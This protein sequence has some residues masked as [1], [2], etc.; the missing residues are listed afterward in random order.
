MELLRYHGTAVAHCPLS[1]AYFAGAVFPLRTALERGLHVGLGSDISG[2]LAGTISKTARTA[3]AASQIRESGVDAEVAPEA[4]ALV[5]RGS[6]SAQPSGWS[7]R[8]G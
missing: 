4:R 8:A 3:V 2:G 1:N 5:R 7:R 6:I